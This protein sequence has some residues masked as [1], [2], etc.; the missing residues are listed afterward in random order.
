MDDT[1]I[2]GVV[3]YICNFF[4]DFFYIREIIDDIRRLNAGNDVDGPYIL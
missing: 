2:V 3:K 4:L 1:M